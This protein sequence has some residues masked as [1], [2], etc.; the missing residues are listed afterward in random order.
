TAPTTIIAPISTPR[1]EASMMPVRSGSPSSRNAP[2]PS[3]ARAST[4]SSTQPS[5]RIRVVTRPEPGRSEVSTVQNATFGREPE[6][7]RPRSERAVSDGAAP[8]DPAPAVVVVAAAAP[9]GA[10][11]RPPTGC[12]DAGS[13]GAGSAG[14]FG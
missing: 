4:A 7:D 1:L 8:P 9:A 14:S 10:A 6:L 5:R 12:G 13:A 2:A 11:S 3:S